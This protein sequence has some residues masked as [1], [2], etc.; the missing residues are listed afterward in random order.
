MKKS[1]LKTILIFSG[2]VLFVG[3]LVGSII[4]V[5]LSCGEEKKDKNALE[6]FIGKLQS[7]K[8]IILEEQVFPEWLL[9]R[10]NE[11]ER[12]NANDIAIIKVKI[13]H[14]EWNG[15]YY[16]LINNNISSCILC[17]IYDEKGAKI[18]LTEKDTSEFYTTS[19]DWKI[20]YEFGNGIY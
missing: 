8:R 9:N 11:I 7:A 15:Q 2:R 3:G 16:Y 20:I 10:I 13:Y 14:G 6:I 19:R 5:N 12:Q 1:I 18:S 17:E 4:T